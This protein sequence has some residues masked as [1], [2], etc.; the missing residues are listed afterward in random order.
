MEMEGEKRKGKRKENIQYR[1]IV[2]ICRYR[3]VVYCRSQVLVVTEVK[4]TYDVR[5]RRYL[6][7][8]FG[9]SVS[10]S[11]SLCPL[12]SIPYDLYKNNVHRC[13]SKKMERNEKKGRKRKK[14][15]EIGEKKKK[16]RSKQIKRSKRSKQIKKKEANK[17]IHPTYRLPTLAT[18]RYL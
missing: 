13:A 9:L 3:S 5:R 12:R 1:C 2:N 17:Q 14:R 16:K 7:R 6:F 15:K 4:G 8:S 10:L 11:L 18:Y